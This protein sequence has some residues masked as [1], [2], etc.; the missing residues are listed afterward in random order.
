M[1]AIYVID[2]PKGL[3]S[4]DVVNQ[5]GKILG[6][7]HLGHTGT[8]DPLATGVLVI[9]VGRATKIIDLLTST[10]KEYLAEVKMGLLTDTLD[11]TG[12][13]LEQVEVPSVSFVELEKTL[14]SFV[15]K[16]EQEV[17]LY[18]A[19]RV[20]GKRLYEYARENQKVVLPKREV[21]IS[22]ITLLNLQQDTFSFSVRVSKG[23][24]IRSLIRDIGVKLQI[25]MSMQNLR[26]LHQGMFSIE[27]AIPL[28][29]FTKQTPGYS[30]SEVL[31]R[32]YPRETISQELVKKVQNGAKIT[33]PRAERYLLLYDEQDHLL[34]L[35]QKEAEHYRAFKIFY[36][37]EMEKCD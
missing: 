34:A 16:Y 32:I 5:M 31:Q 26:R 20:Q 19:V 24:Y 15:G 2:K 30:C 33:L 37:R 17:P 23:T 28:A 25:P 7:K 6:T 35:Y 21:E 1:D 4:R 12:N 3:T 9:A 18:S 10:E 11:I 36:Q 8:L 13:V 29:Q 27:E 14:Q 22:K